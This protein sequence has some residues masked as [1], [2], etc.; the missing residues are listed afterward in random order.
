MKSLGFFIGSLLKDG[1]LSLLAAALTVS[2]L[3]E[4]EPSVTFLHL[5]VACLGLRQLMS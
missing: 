4:I 3:R 1:L 2:L 5:W